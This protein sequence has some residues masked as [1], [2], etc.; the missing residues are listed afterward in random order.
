VEEAIKNPIDKHGLILHCFVFKGGIGKKGK[1]GLLGRARDLQTALA[2]K[3]RLYCRASGRSREGESQ[4]RDSRRGCPPSTRSTLDQRLD[5]LSRADD[6]A[7]A[8]GRHGHRGA[9]QERGRAM[10]PFDPLTGLKASCGQ[11]A[12]GDRRAQGD[13]LAAGAAAARVVE[14]F[15]N[16]A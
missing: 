12:R 16:F 7:D 10:V 6:D 4:W 14:L 9:R 5:A 15:H 3:E 2:E 8:Q 11:C 13:H 1:A